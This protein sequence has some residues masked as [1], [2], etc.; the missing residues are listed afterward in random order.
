MVGTFWRVSAMATGPSVRVSAA[1]QAATVSRGSAGRQ[2]CRFGIVRSA[3]TCST[4]WW[5]GPSSPTKME[6]C[7]NTNVTGCSISAARR[8]A[9]R[10]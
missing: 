1:C 9:G 4:G 8:M 3:A 2:T 6:S 10:M 7:V 5:V